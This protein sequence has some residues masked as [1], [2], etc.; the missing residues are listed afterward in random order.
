MAMLELKGRKVLVL[1]LGDTGLSMARWLKRHGAIV[2]VADTRADPPHAGELSRELPDVA[3]ECGEFR[4]AS[5]RGADLIAI[6]PGVDRRTPAVVAAIERGTPVVGDVELFA[7]ALAQ[8]NTQHSTPNTPR[9]LGITGTN[10]KSTV[11]RMAGDICAAAGLDTMVAGN[12]GTPVLDVL[13]AIE[14][15]RAVPDAF[16]LELSSFQLESTVSLNADAAAMLNISEDHLD[17]YHGIDAYAAAKARVFNGSGAQALNRD[18]KH[19]SAM[20]LPGRTI[21]RFGL[22][23]PRGGNEWGMVQRVRR[24]WLARDERTL[25]P[26]DELPVAGMHNAANALAAGALCHAIGIADA[27]ITAALRAFKGLPHRVE[28]AAVINGI[29]FYDDSKGTNVGSTVAALSGFSQPVV[30]IAG[31]DGKGPGL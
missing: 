28:K 23:A 17:R 5:V 7:Q 14:N 29:T 31:G 16:V 22:D 19:S 3:L 12:I 6:S 11:T 9:I 24:A 20:A 27:P 30:L 21:Y 4:D 25:M 15:G 13:T 2:S 26:I 18:D 1:G 8:L 10:G